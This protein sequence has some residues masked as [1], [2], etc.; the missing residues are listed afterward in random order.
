MKLNPPAWLGELFRVTPIAVPPAATVMMPPRFMVALAVPPE[1]TFCV[2]IGTCNTCVAGTA[3]MVV[4]TASPKTCCVADANVLEPTAVGSNIVP[5][6]VP[7]AL[8]I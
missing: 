6:A 4:L 7:P 2:A 8:T 5:D 3:A 1:S